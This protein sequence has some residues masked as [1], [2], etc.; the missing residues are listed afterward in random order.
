MVLTAACGGGSDKA[1][2][3]TAPAPTNTTTAGATGS[4][5]PT[6]TT[7]V[8]GGAATATTGTTTEATATTET[9]A[10][11]ATTGEAAP[12][13]TASSDTGDVSETPDVQSIDPNALPN[14]TLVATIDE[15]G[16]S[17]DMTGNVTINIEQ[18]AVDNYHLKFGSAD[19]SLETWLVD[20]TTYINDGSGVQAAPADASAFG[21]SPT[22]LLTQ[23]LPDLAKVP[24]MKKV[25]SDTVNG[26][27]TTHYHL[28][29][30]DLGPAMAA[31]GDS[32]MQGVTDGSGNFDIW[33]DND[34]KILIKGDADLTW[35]NADGT[36]G[37]LKYTYEI[38]KIGS[39]DKVSAPATQ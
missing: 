31:M 39:T 7:A 5:S 26:R 3:T 4:S 8:T 14:F 1:T 36:P 35:T 22:D 10:A 11:T 38:S 24:G 17:E 20:G 33:T 27:K 34:L 30:K 12:T 32:D 16:S 21:I 25:G 15:E 28:D 18:S 9:T 37:K 2:S 23:D 13:D 19:Q 6:A 29:G